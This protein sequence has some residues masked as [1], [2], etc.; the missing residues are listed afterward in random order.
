[1]FFKTL[2]IQQRSTAML[3]GQERKN[4]TDFPPW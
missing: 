3:K 4:G 2:D 1:M